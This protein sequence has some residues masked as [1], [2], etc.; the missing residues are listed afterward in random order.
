[1]RRPVLVTGSHRSGT[2]WTGRMLSLSREAGYIHEPL[3]PKRVPGWARQEIPYWWLY[4]CD[5]NEEQYEPVVREIVEFRYPLL[6]NATKAR[7]VKPIALLLQDSSRSLV[8]RARRLRP[9]LKDPFAL[10]SSEWLAARFDMDVVVMIRHPAAFASSL[11]RLNWQFGFKSWLSQELLLRDWLGH[12]EDQMRDYATRNVDVIDQAIL[13]WNAMHESIL[14][15]RQRHRSWIFVRHEDLAKNPLTGFQTLYGHLDLHWDDR[16]ESKVAR[17]SGA[18]NPGE[19]PRWRH[20]SI[21]RDSQGASKTWLNRL[22]REEIERIRVGVGAV[23]KWFY[24][25]DDWT[26]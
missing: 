3:N 20:G 10:F 18:E 16:V 26:A 9:L 23:S 22:S 19:V 24:T 5:D 4:V 12:L 6:R 8:Y 25:D 13:M 1:M 21:R 11:K 15:L 17:F 14:R 2:T 7:G